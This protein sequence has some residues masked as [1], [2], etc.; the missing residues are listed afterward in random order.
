MYFFVFFALFLLFFFILK[1]HFVALLFFVLSLGIVFFQGEF[2]KEL[3]TRD[4]VRVELHTT[5]HVVEDTQENKTADHF[6]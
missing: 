1:N 2:L 4:H 6:D 3:F 5:R